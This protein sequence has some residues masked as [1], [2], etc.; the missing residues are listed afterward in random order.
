MKTIIPV[1]VSLIFAGCLQGSGVPQGNV[2]RFSDL[3]RNGTT[4]AVC[5]P[6]HCPAGRYA[7]MVILNVEATNPELGR[8]LRQNIV[9][10]DQNVRA[11]L[12]KVVT[13]EVDAGFV[14]LTDANLESDELD[15]IEIPREHLPLP[16]Y[17]ISIING[18]KEKE[19]ASLFLEFVTSKEGQGLL[20]EYGFTPAIEDPKPFIKQPQFKDG[21]ILVYAASS[22]TDAFTEIARVFEEKTGI[23]VQN[24]FGS[25]GTLRARIEGGAP[26]DVYATASFKHAEILV[27]E[28]LA[29]DYS[30]FVRNHL[31]VVTRR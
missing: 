28:G 1:L 14:Y 15:V 24:S 12:D 6:G 21:Q 22:L 27:E 11:V 30:V 20:R 4:I 26:A 8:R 25:S 9:T 13:R 29:N 5:D 23:K 3:Y 18:T 31:V 19:A 16:Q 10:N 2:T 7:D 17:G